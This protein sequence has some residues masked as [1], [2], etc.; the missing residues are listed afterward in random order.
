MAQNMPC[1]TKPEPHLA[2]TAPHTVSMLL[3][4]MPTESHVILMPVTTLHM[5]RNLGCILHKA[6]TKT[7][8]V[9]TNAQRPTGRSCSTRPHKVRRSFP[10]R[11][12]WISSGRACTGTCRRMACRSREPRSSVS[13]SALC[14]GKALFPQDHAG[15]AGPQPGSGGGTRRREIKRGNGG[16]DG[17][18]AR[19]QSRTARERPRPDKARALGAAISR[20]QRLPP[21]PRQRR[22]AAARTRWEIAERA[23]THSVTS[24]PQ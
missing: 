9:V 21:S 24:A 18:W 10:F 20:P 2:A 6:T 13:Q 7:R 14:P 16:R 11:T 23:G 15:N 1:G 17:L 22:V 12:F 5:W 19:K 4:S 3:N 8:S